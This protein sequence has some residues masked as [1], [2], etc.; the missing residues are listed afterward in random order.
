M[1]PDGAAHS[2]VEDFSGDCSRD[3]PGNCDEHTPNSCLPA[4]DVRAVASFVCAR[5]HRASALSRSSGR[6]RSIVRA[7]VAAGWY[8][9][10][11]TDRRG[12]GAPRSA[13][14]ATRQSVPEIQRGASQLERA[15]GGPNRRR[16]ARRPWRAASTNLQC[17]AQLGAP[18]G[19]PPP[20]ASP[21]PRSTRRDAQGWASPASWRIAGW[22]GRTQRPCSFTPKL[23]GAPRELEGTRRARSCGRSVLTEP[24]AV[25]Q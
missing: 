1:P 13:F 5:A 19:S 9:R 21:L 3:A 11:P 8:S 17:D 23:T 20:W 14:H 22:Q 12:I 10:W 7:A 15:E 25:C 24:R 4:A 16:T 6:S 2:S 18:L